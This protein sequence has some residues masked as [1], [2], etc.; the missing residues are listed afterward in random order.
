MRGSR[1]TN[2][3]QNT[4]ATSQ[5]LSKRQVERQA[6]DAGGEADDEVAAFP[7]DRAQRGLGIVAA[8]G[9]VDD[10]RAVRA[11]RRLELFG[12]RLRAVLVERL[13]AIDDDLVGARC[14]RNLGLRF[15]R[16][17]RDDARA[18]RLAQFDCC[19]ADAARTRRARATCRLP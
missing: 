1:I 5:L 4:P 6:R 10:V 16:H 9:I 13:I 8:D 15:A 12:E 14:P 7:R 19:D 17:A 18:E 3:P 11:D 2:A